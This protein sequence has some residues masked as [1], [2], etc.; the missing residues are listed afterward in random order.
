MFV[1][2]WVAASALTVAVGVGA[3][4]GTAMWSTASAATLTVPAATTATTAAPHS[5][6]DPTHEAGESAAREAAENNGTA[7]FGPPAAG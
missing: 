7:N 4:V 3:V 2:K 5:N 1:R 6:E